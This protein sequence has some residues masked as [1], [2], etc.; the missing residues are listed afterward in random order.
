MEKIEPLPSML[1]KEIVT[2]S[3]SQLIC[4]ITL[5]RRRENQGER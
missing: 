5:A 4:G 2:S 1:F 3:F